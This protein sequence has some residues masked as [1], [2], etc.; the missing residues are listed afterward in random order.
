M[1]VYAVRV[2]VQGVQQGGPLFISARSAREA[3]DEVEVKM[4]LKPPCITIDKET[5]K[6]NITDWHG[7]EFRARRVH[8]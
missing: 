6:M 3:M 7:Y 5:G 8:E 1:Y 2:F 4:G